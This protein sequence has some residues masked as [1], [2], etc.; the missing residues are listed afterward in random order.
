MDSIS[1]TMKTN[2]QSAG[3]LRGLVCATITPFKENLEVDYGSLEKLY[4]YCLDTEINGIFPMGTNG[5]GILL[6]LEERKRI[7]EIAV[8][9]FR[10]R[11]TVVLHCGANTLKDTIELVRHAKSIGADGVGVIVPGFYK[12]DQRAI[13]EYYSQVLESAVDLPFYLYNIPSRTGV[14]IPKQ[15]IQTLAQSHQNL[16]GMKFSDPSL[17]KLSDYI[18]CDYGRPMDFLIGCDRLMYPAY[19]IGAKG[20]V[21]GPIVAFPKLFASLFKA[22]DNG[23]DDKAIE[24]QRRLYRNNMELKRYQ[25]ILMIKEIL[26]NRGVIASSKC[27]APFYTMNQDEIYSLLK[28]TE[29]MDD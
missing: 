5:E 16:V 24:I 25:E 19:K 18:N 21:S 3:P 15:T 13:I 23:D 14:D 2:I 4:D 28:F 17:E 1:D 8:G 26:K 27:R 10:G 12:Y 9:R 22:I 7:A 11:K 6:T 20:T 29:R